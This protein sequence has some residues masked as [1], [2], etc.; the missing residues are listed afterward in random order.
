MSKCFA[1]Y[2]VLHVFFLMIAE[3]RNCI[4]FET[5]ILWPLELRNMLTVFQKLDNIS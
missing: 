3:L 4:I 5:L 2:E 1:N